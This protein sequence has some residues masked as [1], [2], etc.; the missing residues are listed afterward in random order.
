MNEDRLRSIWGTPQEVD[1]I[2]EIRRE[3]NAVI[4]KEIADANK[5]IPYRQRGSSTNRIPCTR[6][7]AYFS[8]KTMYRHYKRCTGAETTPRR[9]ATKIQDTINL[10]RLNVQ[11][12]DVM[13]KQ[14]LSGMNKGMV[15][16]QIVNDA[17]L[18]QFGNDQCLRFKDNLN[19]QKNNIRQKL[20]SFAKIKIAA[21][22]IDGSI[23]SIRSI[24]NMEKW[25]VCV[26]AIEK[27]A[28]L[29]NIEEKKRSPNNVLAMG[30][31]MKNL[32]Q[33]IKSVIFINEEGELER[34]KIQAWIEL[35]ERKFNSTIGRFAVKMAE[36]FKWESKY[37]APVAKDIV[38]L[39]E[40]LRDRV[41]KTVE[42]LKTKFNLIHWENLN[43]ATMLLLL[44]FN[45]KRLSEIQDL[46]LADYSRKERVR[47]NTDIYM[48]LSETEKILSSR[49]FHVT[50]KGKL[51]RGVPLLIEEKLAGA[52]DLMIEYRGNAKI[53]KT[54]PFLFAKGE[55]SHFNAS[56]EFLEATYECG[57]ESPELLSSTKLRKH[58]ASVTQALE[59]TDGELRTICQFMGHTVKTHEEHYRVHSD[60]VHAAKVS[61]ILIA[62]DQGKLGQYRGK[63]IEDIAVDVT[64]EGMVAP[65]LET[66][67]T[68]TE[69][70]PQPSTS[71][72]EVEPTKVRKCRQKRKVPETPDT[73]DDD[74][75]KPKKEQKRQTKRR[76]PTINSPS[77]VK[78]RG[79]KITSPTKMSPK[80]QK[81]RWSPE[82][83]TVMEREFHSCLVSKTLPSF[84]ECHKL[85]QREPILVGRKPST[86]KAWVF[87]R[88]RKTGKEH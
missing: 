87:N 34:K 27:C 6:C 61:R 21:N 33:D 41:S 18:L 22:E 43:K 4:N 31:L 65:D 52:I 17:D 19:K 24:F 8:R 63:K 71:A 81:L 50:V 60:A 7:G 67:A 15:Y 46:T 16:D 12:S 59:L 53:G 28:Q 55:A 75:E 45:R 1:S 62:L 79:N 72:A 3:G 51:I 54:N 80:K 39:N 20:R 56:K 32:A 64:M 83:I 2:N 73:D 30:L 35:Y 84:L 77:P 38:K 66:T 74:D 86:I 48:G 5:I 69:L 11:L 23:T 76:K 88:N 49:F 47:E 82:E 9:L 29:E 26:K 68:V 42:S 57:A 13:K 70:P 85:R 40:Y 37:Y 25:D 14:I 10:S 36:R 58:I 78:R 44:I